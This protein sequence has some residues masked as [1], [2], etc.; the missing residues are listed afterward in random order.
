MRVMHQQQHPWLHACMLQRAPMELA[1]P[2]IPA[3]LALPCCAAA[4][5]WAAGNSYYSTTD[6]RMDGNA[7][8][9]DHA[10]HC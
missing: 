8:R 6:Y 9:A 10:A 7:G 1:L 2:A 5:P 4:I 3:L